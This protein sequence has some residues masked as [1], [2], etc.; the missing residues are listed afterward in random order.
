MKKKI[1]QE[2]FKSAALGGVGSGVA[3]A[4]IAFY[5]IG[6]PAGAVENAVNNGMAGLFSGAIS[7]FI[8]VVVAA[9]IFGARSENQS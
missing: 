4:A 1:L 3:S 6:M 5:L 2:S 7:G 9:R 8:A